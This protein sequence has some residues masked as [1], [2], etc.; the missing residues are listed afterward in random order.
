VETKKVLCTIGFSQKSLREFVSLLRA[1]G[2][3]KI[4][5]IRLHNTSQLAGFA[6][7]DDL[8]FIL[9]TFGIKYQHVPDLAPT[10][11]I[12]QRFKKLDKDWGAY[13]AAFRELLEKRRA[14]QLWHSPVFEPGVNCLLCAEHSPKRCH[15]RLVAEHFARAH[16]EIEVRHLV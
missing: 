2:V 4:I 14:V 9:E 8:A 3:T 12:L 6:K 1:A 5:D 7:K 10:E 16:P 11:E 15:R 13:E